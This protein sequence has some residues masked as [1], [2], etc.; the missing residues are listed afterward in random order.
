MGG[1]EALESD[2]AKIVTLARSY[3]ARNGTEEG[4]AVRDTDGRTYGASSVS[5]ST[6][7]LPALEA[8]IVVAAASGARRLA[9]AAVVT[10]NAP[11]DVD[12]AVLSGLGEQVPVH[13]AGPDGVVIATRKPGG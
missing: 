12:I 5:L 6:L 4:A 9:A 13:I 1:P 11:E 10:T 3:R 7:A 2:D 8:A